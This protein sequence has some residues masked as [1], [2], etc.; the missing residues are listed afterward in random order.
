MPTSWW[1]QFFLMSCER[2]D[3]RAQPIPRARPFWRQ[4]RVTA[5]HAHTISICHQTLYPSP[6]VTADLIRTGRFQSFLDRLKPELDH[7]WTWAT[8]GLDSDA[9]SAVRSR[10]QRRSVDINRIFWRIDHEYVR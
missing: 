4:S 10:D 9:D 7:L 6:Q 3:H 2:L 8:G 1:D 5:E